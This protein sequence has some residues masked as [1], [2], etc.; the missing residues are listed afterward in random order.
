[1][2]HTRE[3]L[4]YLAKLAE[5]CERYD[6]KKKSFS[7]TN[8]AASHPLSVMGR[9]CFISIRDSVMAE[10]SMIKMVTSLVMRR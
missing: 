3:E 8:S 5:Q 6:G 2:S 10:L 9:L 1:M 4:V 7:Q